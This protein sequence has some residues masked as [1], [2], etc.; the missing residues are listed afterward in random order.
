MYGL[1]TNAPINNQYQN[2]GLMNPNM[3]MPMPIVNPNNGQNYGFSPLGMDVNGN[4]I[5]NQPNPMNNQV[6]P[7]AYNYQ[8]PS[9]VGYSTTQQNLGN[10]GNM[11]NAPNTSNAPLQQQQHQQYPN[12]QQH[13]VDNNYPDFFN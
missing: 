7:Q 9:L 4:Y 11:P 1:P 3:M 12:V 13:Q 2:P 5:N 10:M 6:Y 8:N